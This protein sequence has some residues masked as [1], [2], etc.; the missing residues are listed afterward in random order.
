GEDFFRLNSYRK[1][2]RTIADCASDLNE[3]H[4]RGEIGSLAGVGKAMNEKI[5]ELLTT[6]RLKFFDDLCEKVPCSLLELTAIPGLGPKK[7]LQVWQECGVTTLAELETALD[8]GRCAGLKGWGDKLIE[9]VRKGIT[10]RHKT[11][12][13]TR[14][15][16]AFGI[17]EPLRQR[18]AEWPG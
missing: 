3:L 2:A 17:A 7:A 16:K 18:I 10:F 1:V 5:N 13:R 9:K 4:A 14:L 6:G 15:G 11:A 12:G 8:D